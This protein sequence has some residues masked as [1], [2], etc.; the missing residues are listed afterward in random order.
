MSM[1]VRSNGMVYLSGQVADRLDADAGG[2]MAQILEK[3]DSLLK[4]AGTDK[5]RL[6]T[7]TIWLA[8]M[9]TYVQING[10]WDDWIVTDHAPARACVESKLVTPRHLVEVSA[11]ASA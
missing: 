9:S 1:A 5:S 3:V 8:D 7:V 11:I 10:V 6:V 2:Q 4:E